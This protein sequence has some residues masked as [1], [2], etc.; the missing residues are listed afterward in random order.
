LAD[1]QGGAF[2]KRKIELNFLDRNSSNEVGTT[3]GIPWKKGEI[4]RDSLFTL[5]D[6]KDQEYPVQTWPLAFWPDGS[7]KWS[8]H[9]AAPICGV[10]PYHLQEGT[11]VQSQMQLVVTRGFDYIDVDTGV[12]RCR[13][14]TSNSDI[15]RSIA[16]GGNTVC[17]GGRLVCVGQEEQELFGGRQI[18][19]KAYESHIVSATV[20]QEGPVRGVVRLEGM[21]QA[22]DGGREWLPFT[23]RLYFFAGLADV[24]IVHTFVLDGDKN[25]DRIK[26]IGIQFDIPVSGPL[27][28]R[29]VCFAG[30]T[31]LFYEAAQLLET[32][33]PRIPEKI[34]N[35]QINGKILDLQPE[36]NPQVFSILEKIARWDGYKLV[37]DSADHYVV[38]KR[39]QKECTW[40]TAEQGHRARGLAFVGGA[41][42][43]IAVGMRNF[44]HKCPQSLE[45][46]GVTTETSHMTAWLWS[47]DSNAMDLRDYDTQTHVNSHY[48]GF[49]ELRSTPYGIANTN[50]V[51][52]HCFSSMPEKCELQKCAQQVDAVPLLVCKPEYYHAC[53]TFGVW[54]LPDRSTPAK[55]ALEERLDALLTFYKGEIERREWYGFWN[56]G[57]VMHTYDDARHCWRYDMGGFAWQNTELMPNMWLWY[58]FLRTGRADLFRMAEAMERHTGEVDVYHIGEYAG[59]GLYCTPKTGHGTHMPNPE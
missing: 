47:P 25:R 57:D 8:A 34:Y 9:A 51:R 58:S 53:G 32:W 38:R 59:L 36:K 33:R 1:F 45:I 41:D 19:E 7:V 20:E 55:A 44:W 46:N 11:S 56:Y 21:H 43:G 13:I 35:D 10:A 15:I 3:W 27:Y 23:V 26:G 39:T 17:S 14:G 29:R 49:E 30:E 22:I 16:C 42:S 48:E 37:Q 18:R 50:E 4:S 5:T 2:M 31:G 24:R 54:S 40:I 28:N 12:I 6:S 52:L